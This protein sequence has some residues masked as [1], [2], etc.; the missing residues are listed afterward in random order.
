MWLEDVGVYH[1]K[2]RAYHPKL[3]RFLQTDPIGMADGTNLYSYAGADPVNQKD[4]PG[5][6][7]NEI[8]WYSDFAPAWQSGTTDNVW[9]LNATTNRFCFDDYILAADMF[10]P[11][12]R[13]AGNGQAQA[14]TTPQ[15]KEHQYKISIP[16]MCTADEAFEAFKSPG[17]SAPG[18][19]RAVEGYTDRI[20][21]WGLTGRNNPI[22][23]SVNSSTRTIINTTRPGHDFYPGTVTIQVDPRSANTSTITI[24]GV[25][26]GDHPIINDIVGYAF[27]GGFSASTIYRGCSAAAGAYYVAP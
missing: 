10:A 26:T 21:L 3:G 11:E 1:Y 14:P 7:S 16:T 15:G 19:P 5:L 8:T 12:Y 18:A 20:M 27:F 24:T 22:S 13:Y 2:A 23:Q 4:P 17:F 9:S 25:G 6:C